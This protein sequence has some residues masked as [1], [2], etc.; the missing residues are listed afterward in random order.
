MWIGKIFNVKKSNDQV[1]ASVQIMK[2]IIGDDDRA[3]YDIL[4]MKNNATF[5][6]EVLEDCVAGDSDDGM[7]YNIS[8]ACKSLLLM[9]IKK[10][11][12]RAKAYILDE[13]NKGV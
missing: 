2:D 12:E 3:Y 5:I 1:P 7:D 10:I 9:Q 4:Q 13:D 11:E 8:P 6:R